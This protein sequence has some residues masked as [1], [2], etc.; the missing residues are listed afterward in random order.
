MKAAARCRVDARRQYNPD[1]Q[2]YRPA[3]FG[4]RWR[5][6]GHNDESVC[7]S[8]RLGDTA[9]QTAN[10]TAVQLDG[11]D[12]GMNVVGNVLGSANTTTV[13]AS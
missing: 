11:G 5:P 1:R 10:V 6:P 8:F 9:V 4:V 3:R 12:I 13:L 2:G 7:F